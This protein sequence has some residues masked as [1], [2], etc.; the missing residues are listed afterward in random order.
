MA[1]GR[2]LRSVKPVNLLL[3]DPP[4]TAMP[5]PRTDARAEHLLR[6]LKRQPG[7][8]FDAGLVNGPR[9][10]GLLREITP[11]A[12][13]LEFT[14]TQPAQPSEPLT[15]LVG[16]PRP[17]TARDVLRD[18]TTLGVG[19]LHFVATEKSDPAYARSSLWSTGEW[20]RHVLAGAAQ[21]FDTRIPAVTAG[22]PLA[23]C[24]AALPPATG[25]IALDNYEATAP[26]AHLVAD[27]PLPAVLAIGPE[28]GW[29]ARDRGL[30]RDHG[31]ALAHLG[32]RVLRTET[33]VISALTLART[34]LDRA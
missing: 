8:A 20:R 16:L 3:F 32:P 10:R 15:L 11:T 7:D 34:R 1:S 6:V 23:A 22:E 18:A 2:A 19:A 4:E 24:L 17:Q 31:F 14:W 33:A 13:H 9:G 27:L 21:A 28:R 25:R 26:L 12:L 30:L 5:L 29:T